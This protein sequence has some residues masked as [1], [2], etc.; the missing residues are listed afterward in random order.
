MARTRIDRICLTADPR[1]EL[2]QLPPEQIEAAK[3]AR[4][5]YLAKRRRALWAELHQ[6]ADADRA[7]LTAWLAHVPCGDCKA[8]AREILKTLPP[9]F[10]A[11]W[12]AWTVAFHNA[13]NARLG[14]PQVTVW[15]ARKLWPQA[16][17]K[18]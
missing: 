12:F 9:M 17:V 1:R 11:G 10:G 4:A 5:A 15:V 6:K 16:T 13:V 14:K 7:W 8:H 2:P 18:V 3:K